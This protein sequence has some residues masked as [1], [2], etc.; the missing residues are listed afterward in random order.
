MDVF[1]GNVKIGLSP[2]TDRWP[3]RLRS[4]FPWYFYKTVKAE[5]SS[6]STFGCSGSVPL[7]VLCC[8]ESTALP[9]PPSQATSLWQSSVSSSHKAEKGKVT[10]EPF[11]LPCGF[12]LF[13]HPGCHR[14]RAGQRDGLQQMREVCQRQ[15]LAAKPAAAVRGLSISRQKCCCFLC[16]Y[17][18]C[19]SHR[20]LQCCQFFPYSP[21]FFLSPHTFWE[22]HNCLFYFFGVMRLILSL[23]SQLSKVR[24][25]NCSG[26]F[27]W[28]RRSIFALF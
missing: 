13:P 11:S 12:C 5:I 3:S 18:F 10:K 23:R 26:T 20:C 9:R 2:V 4:I 1:T 6:P 22:V 25:S 27:R 17:H 19:P 7:F 14:A 24:E 15:E 8:L 21:C 28:N 16:L